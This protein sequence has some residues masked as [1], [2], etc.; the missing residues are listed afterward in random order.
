MINK[1]KII[2]ITDLA[3]LMIFIVQNFIQIN[4]YGDLLYIIYE[5]Y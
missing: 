2:I 4:I 1:E 5:Y 3:K